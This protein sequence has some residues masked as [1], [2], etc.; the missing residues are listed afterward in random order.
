MQLTMFD[1]YNLRARLSVYMIVLSPLLLTLYFN[2]EV[3]RSLGTSIIII[4]FVAAF[5]NYFLIEERYHRKNEKIDKTAATMLYHENTELNE[6][7]KERYYRKLAYVDQT[8]LPLS[9]KTDNVLFKSS[10]DEAIIWLRNNSRDNHL[11]QEENILY[12]FIRNAIRARTTGLLFLI[13]SLIVQLFLVIQSN[14]IYAIEFHSTPL[15]LI[16]CFDIYL[17]FFWTIGVTEKKRAF[18]ARKYS[19]ALLST[20]D[21]IETPSKE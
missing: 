3:I 16:I 14:A 5:S 9:S 21:S 12:G 19:I 13:T 6:E 15:I 4:L 8:F 18:I 10:C 7:T 20:I 11:V 1:N 2:F 17:T